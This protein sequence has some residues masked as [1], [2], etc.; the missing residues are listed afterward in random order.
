MAGLYS[1][2]PRWLYT[3]RGC[4]LPKGPWLPLS[5]GRCVMNIFQVAAKGACLHPFPALVALHIAEVSFGSCDHASLH[6][7]VQ[8]G[9]K[10]GLNPTQRAYHGLV[11]GGVSL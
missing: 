11:I 5:A 6:R 3:L 4:G 10:L 9:R 1:A 7:A 8:L 2:A